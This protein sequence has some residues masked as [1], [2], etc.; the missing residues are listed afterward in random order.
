MFLFGFSWTYGQKYLCFCV[1]QYLFPRILKKNQT[2][3][4]EG[5]GVKNPKD[6]PGLKSDHFWLKLHI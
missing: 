2:Y 5:G 4:I 1:V 3:Q 6:A